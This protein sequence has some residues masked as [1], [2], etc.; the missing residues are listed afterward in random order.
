MVLILSFSISFSLSNESL[1][2]LL[3]LFYLLLLYNTKL[4]KTIYQF[5]E[6]FRNIK[7]L[8]WYTI[9]SATTVV[10]KIASEIAR[11]E[12][13]SNTSAYQFREDFRNIKKLL[14]YTITSATTVV[15]KIASEVACCECR[16]NTSAFESRSF[17][18]E[19][20]LINQV[21]CFFKRPGFYEKLKY[22]FNENCGSNNLYDIY[23]GDI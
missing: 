13:G 15:K 16:S 8:L 2:Q 6:D 23:D 11:C 19:L 7:K 22:R 12:C 9:T 17:Y 21:L 10:K 20:S 4:C 3:M 5:R 1:L 18:I 14:W